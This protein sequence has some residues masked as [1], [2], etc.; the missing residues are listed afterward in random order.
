MKLLTQVLIIFSYSIVGDLLSKFLPFP[1]PGSI[2]GLLLLFFSMKMGFIKLSQIEETGN[3]LKNN[4]AILFVPLSVG[5]MN[6]FDILKDHWINIIVIILLSTTA[7]YLIAA[8]IAEAS[9]K[10]EQI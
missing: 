7:T 3:W 1:I 9:I 5:I 2:L 10:G 6:Y 4:M 8:K